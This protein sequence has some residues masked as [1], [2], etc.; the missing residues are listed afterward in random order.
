MR[1]NEAVSALASALVILAQTCAAAELDIHP[2]LPAAA[3]A[4]QPQAKQ[5]FVGCRSNT[6]LLVD[7]W[8]IL[9]LPN[10]TRYGYTDSTLAAA[11]AGTSSTS[12]F[13][14]DQAVASSQSQ[15]SSED[16]GTKCAGGGHRASHEA[17]WVATRHL[18]RLSSPLSR[19]LM[20][21]YG[22]NATGRCCML[23]RTN[24]L[25]CSG[26]ACCKYPLA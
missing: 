13:F 18:N 20:P 17:G 12:G 5:A 10:G 15:Q 26:V 8:V 14:A 23:P 11:V 6:G 1:A 22:P 9:K 3:L 16:G 7:W 2:S 21:L 4:G 19:T 25:N 24:L